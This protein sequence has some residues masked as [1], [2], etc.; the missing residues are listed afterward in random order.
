MSLLGRVGQY[1]YFFDRLQNPL[2]LLPLKEKGIFSAPPKAIHNEAEGTVQYDQW[3][4]SRYLARMSEIAEA[5]GDV[6]DVA[7]SVPDTDDAFVHLDLLRVAANLPPKLASR[8][9]EQAPSWIR[10]GCLLG[11]TRAAAALIVHL[12]KGGEVARALELTSVLFQLLPS[13]ADPA[14]PNWPRKVRSRLDAG[15]YGE[16]IDLVIE[17]LANAAG[18]EALVVFSSLLAEAV[19]SS[20]GTD[21][22]DATEDYSFIWQPTVGPGGHHRHD[23]IRHSLVDAVRQTA[24]RLWA[25]TTNQDVRVLEILEGYRFSVFLRIVLF[26]LR[27]KPLL[28]AIEA[29]LASRQY[30]DDLGFRREY[31]LLL[32][33][34]YP[35]LSELAREQLIAW[36]LTAP[37]SEEV[38]KTLSKRCQLERLAPL[39]GL[40]PQAAQQLHDQLVAELGQPDRPD[41][42]TPRVTTWFGPRSPRTAAELDAMSDDEIVAFVHD[43]KPSGQIMANSPEGLARVITAAVSANPDRFAIMAPRLQGAPP[44]YVRGAIYG[45]NEA[46]RQGR[47]FSW[48]PVLQLCAWVL[49][50]P[51]DYKA[52]RSADPFEADPGW[53][54]TRRAIAQ[55]V[56]AG[57]EAQGAVIPQGLRE[58]VWALLAALSNDQNPDPSYEAEYGGSNMDPVTLSLNTT[59]GTALHGVVRYVL[60]VKGEREDGFS[61]AEV[62][63]ARDVLEAHLDT[64]SEP[65][66]AVRAVYGQWFPWL[67]VLDPV[68]ATAHVGAVFPGGD[69]NDQFWQAAWRAYVTFNAP[70]NNVVPVL[71]DQYRTAVRKLQSKYDED[72]KVDEPDRELAEHLVVL[73]GRGCL[74]DEAVFQEF[75]RYA[76]DPL[77]AAA[78][79]YVGWTLGQGGEIPDDVV[80]RFQALWEQRRAQAAAVGPKPF[81]K[82]LAAFGSWAAFERFPDTWL[83]AELAQ[84]LALVGDVD[85]DSSVMERLAKVADSHPREAV[86]VTQSMVEHNPGWGPAGWDEELTGV[87]RAA[88]AT[89]DPAVRQDAEGLI[90]LLGRRGFLAYRE[91]LR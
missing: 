20:R 16:M 75:F 88:L 50:Q 48:E 41:A 14:A 34:F 13:K 86:R 21:E 32:R 30:F 71:W 72:G 58:P 35:S 39:N 59:R 18:V 53:S 1:R 9:A 91:L 68:W 55:L 7:L 19:V 61:L 70:Y 64:A 43:W 74:P 46:A 11:E 12:A 87:L 24:L 67:V 37:T 6:L 77:R 15:M 36:M 3:P 90:D 38:D 69:P 85:R 57:L 42:I 22:D 17:P 78:I 79:S 52:E 10:A 25:V 4:A 60:W 40:M 56:D 5:H 89:E 51:F 33:D 82:E 76:S 45:F 47:P 80:A 31:A 81:E 63:E 28:P 49:Q 44:T 8:L 62:P 73:F 23:D 83:L 84:V 66:L 65:S 26:I 2:W 29:R 27:E 54:W